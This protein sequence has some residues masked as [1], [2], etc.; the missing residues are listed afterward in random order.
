MTELTIEKCV[1]DATRKLGWTV[2]GWVGGKLSYYDP[3]REHAGCGD[4]DPLNNDA[5]AFYLMCA[6][7]IDL[8]H[9]TLVQSRTC[10]T[11]G[12]KGVRAQVYS[13]DSF[14]IFASP[15]W[16]STEP[17]LHQDRRECARIVIVRAAAVARVQL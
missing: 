8:Q 6:L 7:G 15:Y 1:E 4:W 17:S 12:A 11:L 2:F 3:I 16:S 13:Q 5:D 10:D 9:D 14:R